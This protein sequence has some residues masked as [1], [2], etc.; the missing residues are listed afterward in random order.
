[1]DWANGVQVHVWVYAILGSPA[2]VRLFWIGIASIAE[3]IPLPFGATQ[4]FVL[5][6]LARRW[7]STCLG[8]FCKMDYMN[9]T[10]F[11]LSASR[12]A[13]SVRC[14]HRVKLLLPGLGVQYSTVQEL[15]RNGRK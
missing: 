7:I 11:P 9:T 3:A 1:M 10:S 5:S 14:H 8:F 4:Y 15:V 13:L 12:I 6:S 2:L